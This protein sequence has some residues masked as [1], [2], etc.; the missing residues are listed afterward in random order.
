MGQL[1]GDGWWRAGGQH[2][3]VGRHALL[4][5]LQSSQLDLHEVDTELLRDQSALH[6]GRMHIARSQ[7]ETALEVGVCGDGIECSVGWR[8]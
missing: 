4:L 2:A 6:I 3:L 7:A 5:F 8:Q 1:S